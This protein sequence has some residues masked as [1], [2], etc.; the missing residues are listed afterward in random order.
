LAAGDGIRRLERG[1]LC[2]LA[3]LRERLAACA[4]RRHLQDGADAPRREHQ[5]L[6]ALS[7]P[8]VQRQRK[9]VDR[10]I[11][12]HVVYDSHGTVEQLP[13]ARKHQLSSTAAGDIQDGA[14]GERRFIG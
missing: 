13:Q 5:V 4:Q 6:P 7:Q 1:S 9:R 2:Q 11:E 3:Q 14:G 8:A 12:R 10:A